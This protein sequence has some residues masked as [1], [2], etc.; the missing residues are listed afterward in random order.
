MLLETVGYAAEFSV[1]RSIENSSFA[2]SGT[3]APNSAVTI[4]VY[5]PNS[6]WADILTATRPIDVVKY[7][8]EVYADADGNFDLDIALDSQSGVYPVHMIADGKSENFSLE[9]VDIDLN[10]DAIDDFN[11]AT[12]KVTFLA[13]GN[14]RENLGFFNTLYDSPTAVKSDIFTLMATKRSTF[15]ITKPQEAIDVFNEAV[16]AHS[17]SKGIISG[18]SANSDE[19]AILNDGGSLG[20]WYKLTDAASVDA[21]LSGKSF[22]SLA[23]FELAVKEAVILEIV[24]NPNGYVNVQNVM[25]DFSTEIGISSLS[26]NTAL[27][28]TLAG[29]NFATLSKLKTAYDTFLGNLT[30]QPPSGGGGSGGGGGAGS[31][32]SGSGI[33]YSNPST[34]QPI[35]KT[36]FTDMED[37]KWAIDAVTYLAENDV[38]SGKTENEFYPKDLVKREEFVTMIVRAFRFEKIA[39]IQQFDDVTRDVWFYEYV[40]AANQNEVVS[41]VSEKLFGA[42]VHI[43]RQDMAVI[44]Y[45]TLRTK[46]IN[47]EEKADDSAFN[48]D[49]EIADYAKEAVHKLKAVGIVSGMENNCFMPK[50]EAQRA[51]AAQMIY[52]VLVSVGGEL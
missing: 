47:L 7:H 40:T 24:K 6:T 13:T 43:T 49:A 36:Y 21:R 35:K 15:D 50:K 10:D 28:Q 5:A 34:P 26:S 30:T 32:S 46:N 12:D 20:G 31:S 2:I 29:Q 14:N 9:F 42:G 1:I 18:I 41:G 25:R 3:A 33:I 8:N 48:D 16:I 52:N 22:A 4:E 51:E 39:D 17:L 37:T 11:G 27:Y 45:N 44:L 38:V 23:E 19:L